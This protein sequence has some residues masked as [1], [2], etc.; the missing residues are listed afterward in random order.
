MKRKLCIISLLCIASL[1]IGCASKMTVEKFHYTVGE[2]FEEF[3][4]D[5]I[6]EY[7]E[8]L[9][10][11]YSRSDDKEKALHYLVKAGDK[12]K[13]AY[14]NK[15]AIE[16]YNQALE[17]GNEVQEIAST[18]RG[19]IYQGLAEI[20][21]LLENHKEALEFAHKALE[22]SA[23][24]RQRASIYRI[25]GYA[26]GGEN[27]LD[28][29]IKH[30][31]LAIAELG[32][33]TDLPEMGLIS[34]GLFWHTL[35]K[36]RTKEAIEIAQ[37]GLEIVEGTEHYFELAG[38]YICLI[39]VNMHPSYGINERDKGFEYARKSF[40]AAQKS[41]NLY[42]IGHSTFWLGW[43]HMQKGEN[44]VA[45]ELMTEAIEIYKKTGHV[46][47]IR[48]AYNWLSSIYRKKWDWQGLKYLSGS[49]LTK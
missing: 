24:N 37:H 44:D 28:L 30:P 2:G 46:F 48:Q 41:G 12:S 18:M 29:A 47:H 5:K 34:Y 26:Y 16:Y 31:N 10:Y 21:W 25:M 35:S 23:D 6:E 8:E 15:R 19:H 32:D 4:A 42:A 3:Y 27:K 36:G 14:A 49:L 9:A 38:L 33:E 20:S 7:Y 43:A 13:A 1:M 22:S 17:Q 40:E 39:W 45:I 11:H